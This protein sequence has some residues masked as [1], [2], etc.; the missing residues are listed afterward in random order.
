[1]IWRDDDILYPHARLSDLLAVDDVLR[2]FG[3]VH[4]VAVIAETLTP[5]LG[6]I[7]QDRGMVAQLH[8]WAHDDLSVNAKAIAQLPMAVEKIADLCGQ[9]P[10]V[11]Y[12]PW[13]R[14]N[15]R[16]EAV[17]MALGLEVSAEKLSLE[18]IIRLRA[19]VAHDATV[20]FH[21]WHEPDREALPQALQAFTRRAA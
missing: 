7:I 21:F 1:M 16:L 11:L 9:T 20:N 13:N 19:M 15:A 12:P 3:C 8:C 4:T 6:R 18:Q 14:T 5:E 17:A 2:E 10:T